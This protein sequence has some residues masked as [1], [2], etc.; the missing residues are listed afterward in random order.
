MIN[1][2]S[3]LSIDN[4]DLAL[5]IEIIWRTIESQNVHVLYEFII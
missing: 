1:P 4:I 2:W 5:K 3:Q